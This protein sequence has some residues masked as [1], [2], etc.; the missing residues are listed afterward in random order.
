MDSW[1]FT[2][3][4]GLE[5]NALQLI[6]FFK[7][8]QLFDQLLNFVS[9]LNLEQ[10]LIVVLL[11]FYLIKKE[12]EGLFI[13]LWVLCVCFLYHESLIHV[14]RSTFFFILKISLWEF[15]NLDINLCKLY[16]LFEACLFT[17]FIVSFSE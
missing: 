15:Y 11:D 8:C 14:F 2:S 12:L 3:Y 16:L 10:C 5:S 1:K 13:I 7:L 9:L 4:S 17:P 6:L